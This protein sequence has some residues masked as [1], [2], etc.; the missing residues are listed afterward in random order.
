MRYTPVVSLKVGVLS[1]VGSC[2]HDKQAGSV[3]PAGEAAS[4]KLE[5]ERWTHPSRAAEHTSLADYRAGDCG[6]RW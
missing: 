2:M 6:T 5:E 4:F 1:R 3:R